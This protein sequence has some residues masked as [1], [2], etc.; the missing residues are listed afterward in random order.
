MD[1]TP[2]H[3]CSNT[4]KPAAPVLGTW[5]AEVI[6]NV[7]HLSCASKDQASKGR[8]RGSSMHF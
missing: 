1:A 4:V 3:E 2:T 8:A 6:E 5:W 7:Q